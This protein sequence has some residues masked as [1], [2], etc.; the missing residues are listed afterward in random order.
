MCGIISAHK[1]ALANHACISSSITAMSVAV[2]EAEILLNAAPTVIDPDDP[3]ALKATCVLDGER[4]VESIGGRKDTHVAY[5][6]G[7][8][9]TEPSRHGKKPRLYRWQP[10][11]ARHLFRPVLKNGFQ[12]TDG[13][14]EARY[15]ISVWRSRKLHTAEIVQRSLWLFLSKHNPEITRSRASDLHD[16]NG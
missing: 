1:Q 6:L 11:I 7:Q 9:I 13:N 10:T 4:R 3:E 5:R 2:H 16:G 14:V 12:I 15:Y 8:H